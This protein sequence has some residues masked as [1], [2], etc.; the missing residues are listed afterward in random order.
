MKAFILE[1]PR[2]FKLKDNIPIPFPRKGEVLLKV[3]AAGICGSDIPRIMVTGAYHHPLIPGHEFAG[4]VASVGEGVKEELIGMRVTVYPLIPCNSCQW[5]KKG[6]Y[7]LCENYD[8]MGSRRDGAFAEY[9]CVP[10]S[11]LICIPK[12]IPFEHAALTEPAAVALHGL[13]NAKIRNG[14]NVVIFG[15]GPIG[16]IICQIARLLGADSIWIVDVIDKKLDIAKKYGWAETINA[17]E[18]NVIEEVF[19]KLPHG[20]ELVIDTSGASN[21]LYQAITITRKHGRIL[22]VG[23]PHDDMKISKQSF[24]NILRHELQLIGTWNSLIH[25]EWK[26]IIRWMAT[27][28]INVEPIITHRIS[29]DELPN[30][31]KLMYEKKMIYEKVL[32][33]I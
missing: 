30:I 27:G 21:A 18:V 24:E 17:S 33:I 20:A 31:I 4:E 12:N 3:K 16:L 11:N 9:I 13:K 25:N 8:Y 23:N 5:C 15:A 6:L 29:L 14:D 28:K 10:T 32:V 1:A 19:S 7:N 2:V 26:Q 22:L